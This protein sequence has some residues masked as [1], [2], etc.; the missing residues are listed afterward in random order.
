MVAF[1]HLSIALCSP[2]ALCDRHTLGA[3]CER[4]A[5]EKRTSLEIAIFTYKELVKSKYGNPNEVTFA[6]FLTALRN[7]LPPS[8]G[9]SA[10]VRSVFETAANDGRVNNLVLRRVQSALTSKELHDMFPAAISE[11][12]EVQL[13]KLPNEWRRNVN[14][15]PRRVRK[16]PFGQR[17]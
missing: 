13:N 2:L 16:S 11:H 3:Y 15:S 4:D 5:A 14:S 6:T 17:T 1:I 10:A 12:G 9:R 7:L 8:K